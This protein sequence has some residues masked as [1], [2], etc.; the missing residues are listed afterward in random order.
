MSLGGSTVSLLGTVE[1]RSPSWCGHPA[2]LVADAA[3]DGQRYVGS[4]AEQALQHAALEGAHR[5]VSRWRAGAHR[6]RRVMSSPATAIASRRWPHAE[7]LA[8]H[9]GARLERF[10]GG[11]LLQ[12]GRAAA[13]R[14]MA[15]LVERTMTELGER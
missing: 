12:F 15:P 4:P 7:R 5:A 13:F 14:A 11:H 1:E 10:P 6:A 3:R 8:T 9:F 2:R